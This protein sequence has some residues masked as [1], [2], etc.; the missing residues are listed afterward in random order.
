MA[1]TAALLMLVGAAAALT[2]LIVV[3]LLPTGLNPLRDPVSQYGITR[4]RGWYWAAAGGAAVA[5]VGGALFFS[6]ID[7]V[8][9]KVTV[10]LLV[11][12]F[13]ARA[14]IG[15]FPM[16]EPGE[17]TTRRGRTHNLLATLAFASVTA[18]AF[19]A[20][21]A[22]HDGGFADAAGWS[23]VLGVVMA[24]GAVGLV[25]GRRLRGIFGLAERL[26]YVGFIAWFVLIGVLALGGR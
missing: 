12:F 21:G 15:F 10:I 24:V 2:A 25:L 3:H 14:L 5:G 7:T 20:A 8:I 6:L 19:T 1:M 22:L 17:A 4:Y 23:P 18:A 26:I 11:G 16:D 9:A 13:V